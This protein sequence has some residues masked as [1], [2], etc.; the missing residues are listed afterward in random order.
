MRRLNGIVESEFA[1]SVKDMWLYKGSLKYFGPNGWTNVKLEGDYTLPNATETELGG[2]YRAAYVGT[3]DT[4][5]ELAAVTNKVNSIIGALVNAG[6]M[7]R[8]VS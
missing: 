6:I 3:L 8:G 1:P 4:T 5:A 2:V 7:T